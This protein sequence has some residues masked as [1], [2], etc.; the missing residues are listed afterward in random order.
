MM[1]LYMALSFIY[2]VSLPLI[3]CFIRPN[4][5]SFLRCICRTLSLWQAI[6][7]RTCSCR[8]SQDSC[9]HHQRDWS[10]A[11]DSLSILLPPW[12]H[13]VWYLSSLTRSYC[14][15]TSIALLWAPIYFHFLSSPFR[16]FISLIQFSCLSLHC[17]PLMKLDE[18]ALN[19]LSGPL[20]K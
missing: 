6:R 4:L 15:K 1:V 20:R 11:L 17:P 16:L 9:L 5:S 3:S 13:C 12:D 18:I 8:Q 14:Q 19:E 10:G 7:R 2:Y